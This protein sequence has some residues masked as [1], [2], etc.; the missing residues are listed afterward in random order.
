[1]STCNVLISSA[2]RRVSLLGSF[3]TALDALGVDGAVYASDLSPL[4]AAGHAADRLFAAPPC[5][6]PEFI[7][8]MLQLCVDHEISLVVPTIDTELAAYAAHR[9]DF[10]AVG[11]TIAVSGPETVAI[12]ADK[13]H[14]HRWLIENDLPTVDQAPLT[15]VLADPTRLDFPVIVKPVAGSASAGVALINELTELDAHDDVENIIVQEVAPGIE[16]TVDAYV[17]RAG[18]VLT[19]VPRR[20]LEV[21]AG[22]VSKAITVV[23]DELQALVADIVTR[24]PATFGALNVQVFVAEDRLSVIEMNP[25]F[26]GGFPLS[27][28]AGARMSEWLV[29]E[30]IG[31]EPD[32]GPW[33]PGVVMLRYDD[34][35]FTNA[36]A[37]GL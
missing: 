36:S 15:E 30:T 24:L 21:R 28:Q 26:G 14:T 32:V 33:Q 17:D 13:R 10:A 1:M 35:V 29:A 11:T 2:G 22:E 25:R 4:T 19:T 12:A 23:H 27:L 5:R 8:S 3:R 31:R 9:D 34:A 7:P 6:A 37:V 18:R 20:R 16:H